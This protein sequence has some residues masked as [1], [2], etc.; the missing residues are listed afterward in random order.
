MYH[1][2]MILTRPA[3]PRLL[4]ALL[5]LGSLSSG[6]ISPAHA[7]INEKAQMLLGNPDKATSDSKN[8]KH[9]LV[10]RP[11]FAMSYND[12]LRWPNWVSW[13][14]DAGDI[15][16]EPRSQFQPDSSLPEGYTVI[17]PGDYT[18]S[19]YDRGHNCPSADRSARAEDNKAV[20]LMSNMTPQAHGMNAGPW[21]GLESEC[22]TLARRGHSLHIIAGHGFSSPSYGTI[23]KKKIAVPDFSWKVVV[24]APK[25]GKVDADCRVI[26][27]RMPNNNTI[28]K[29]RWQEYVTTARELEKA[30]SLT[31]FDVLPANIAAA[32]RAK[33]DSDR[34]EI[35]IASSPSTTPPQGSGP[36]KQGGSG[37]ASSELSIEEATKK[38]FV[39]VNLS[40]GKYW[41]PGTQYYGLTK[42]GKFMSE[43]DAR[44]AGYVAV[45]GQ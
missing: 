37:A 33:K 17:T 23:G 1:R 12:A 42:R 16:R 9:F 11:Q 18:R 40:S 15:G 22:R 3:R 2:D 19:G 36:D 32:L 21:E 26:A 6:M 28:S 29:K 5:V 24:V 20:F 43:A 41:M 13:K 30:T 35:S 4:A 39:W 34:K 7:E 14:L 8:K 44:A 27:V 25:S 45:K 10:R 31:F 38:G